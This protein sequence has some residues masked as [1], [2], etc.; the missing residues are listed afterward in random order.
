MNDPAVYL[1]G[2]P[3]MKEDLTSRVS[4]SEVLPEN[5]N[6][7]ARRR[8]Q[9]RLEKERKGR[10]DMFACAVLTGHLAYSPRSMFTLPLED[11]CSEII[12]VADEMIRQ[13]DSEPESAGSDE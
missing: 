2:R 11:M 1:N 5:L 9:I 7:I 13:L 8:E 4:A 10:R 3:V 6:H 12:N